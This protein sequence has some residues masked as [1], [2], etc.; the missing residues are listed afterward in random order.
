MLEYAGSRRTG[1]RSRRREAGD[2]VAVVRG[3]DW[4]LFGG[5]LA[6]VGVGLWAISGITLHDVTDRPHYFLYRQSVYAAV[7]IAGLVVATL[8]DPDV[9]RRY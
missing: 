1:A 9:Y 4:I 7:G 3:I 8:I 5:V 6:L 2:L